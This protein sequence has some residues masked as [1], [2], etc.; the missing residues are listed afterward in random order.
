VKQNG[1]APGNPW[2]FLWEKRGVPACVFLK[3]IRWHQRLSVPKDTRRP[4]VKRKDI[5]VSRQG[6]AN[7]IKVFRVSWSAHV[8]CVL[9]EIVTFRISPNARASKTKSTIY[10]L[11]VSTPLKN[12]SQ[13]GLLPI[14]GK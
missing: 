6:E 14:Y 4:R 9:I 12:V 8:H 11:V 13:L 7:S 10:W 1:K 3:P 5:R 2:I